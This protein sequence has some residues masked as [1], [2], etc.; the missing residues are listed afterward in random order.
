[1]SSLLVSAHPV[2]VD[3]S[4]RPPSTQGSLQAP[5]VGQPN[6]TRGV[7]SLQDLFDGNTRFRQ[8]A[9]VDA[10][11][12]ANEEPSFMFLG[13]TDNRLS[14]GSIFNAPAGS[15]LAHNN[16]GNQYSPKDASAESA[17]AYAVEDLHVQH[18][19]VLGHYG[20]KGAETAITG[21]NNA[22]RYIRNWVKSITELYTTSRRREIVIL[23]DSR[24]PKR[25]RDAGVK[26]PPPASDAG[27]RALVEE[28]VK[29]TVDELQKSA[30]LTEA[31][32]KNN[33]GYHT[34]V[35]GFVY[36]EVTGVV[37]DLGISFGP[38]GV[39]IPHVPFKALAA[40]RNYHRG[41][42]RPHISKGKSWEFS[43]YFN[44]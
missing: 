20:C 16:I 30:V 21:S 37:H 25:G 7:H 5:S 1:M 4:P 42:D 6:A 34:F 36:D 29:R 22:S 14:P 17:I 2:V 15:I 31:Y 41:N 13:C 19:I 27:F 26:T 9:R 44:S 12:L 33:S 3:L 43:S 32:K 38:R 18:I 10:Q 40:A 35:H 39:P 23:R 28:N 24:K 8:S 11:K